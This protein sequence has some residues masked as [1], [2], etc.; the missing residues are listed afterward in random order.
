MVH[1]R[2]RYCRIVYSLQCCRYKDFT[3]SA[4]SKVVVSFVGNKLYIDIHKVAEEHIQKT[5]SPSVLV[6]LC[7]WFC[8]CCFFFFP[9]CSFSCCFPV[10]QIHRATGAGCHLP[11]NYASSKLCGKLFMRQHNRGWG[12]GSRLLKRHILP[13]S[14]VH[15]LALAG[16]SLSLPIVPA[17]QV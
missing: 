8:F 4:K 10:E 13:L 1:L 7:L 3:T 11:K 16:S 14:L 12:D 17:G 9:L 6:L 15:C 5:R 2:L